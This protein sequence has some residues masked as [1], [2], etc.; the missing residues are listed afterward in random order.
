[1]AEENTPVH[2]IIHHEKTEFVIS[3]YRWKRFMEMSSC[4]LHNF[5]T[6]RPDQGQLTLI[7]KD[8]S[9]S[10][11][12]DLDKCNF[13]EGFELKIKASSLTIRSSGKDNLH[14]LF[15]KPLHGGEATWNLDDFKSDSLEELGVHG[16][17]TS[18][19]SSEDFPMLYVGEF[20]KGAN[21]TLKD[22][23]MDVLVTDP[24]TRVSFTGKCVRNVQTSADVLSSMICIGEELKSLMER[25]TTNSNAAYYD[26]HTPMWVDREAFLKKCVS[27]ELYLALDHVLPSLQDKGE[28]FL[29]LVKWFDEEKR[30]Q[31][32]KEVFLRRIRSALR[33]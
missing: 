10:L 22:I 7:I 23:T 1:M 17:C 32:Q 29:R 5:S 21:L 33:S 15:L 6:S 18:Q 27:N 11:V 24:E 19:L 25:D 30:G 20:H 12:L 16:K 28:V 14:E 3:V 13:P 31:E 26:F 8:K 2:G 4:P 9:P